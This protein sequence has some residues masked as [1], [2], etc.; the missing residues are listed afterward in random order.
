MN[1][2]LRPIVNFSWFDRDLS[3]RPRFD[4][5]CSPRNQPM[6]V[7]GLVSSLSVRQ[8]KRRVV[9]YFETNRKLDIYSNCMFCKLDVKKRQFDQYNIPC[10]RANKSNGRITKRTD[11]RFSLVP[12]FPCSPIKT[13]NSTIKQALLYNYVHNEPRPAQGARM[14]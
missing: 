2:T 13:K 5:S 12:L 7:E 1:R 11:D 9:K 10:M 3:L 6:S 14:G 8:R 4:T